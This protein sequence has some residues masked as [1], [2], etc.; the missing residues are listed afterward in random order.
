MLVFQTLK[1]SMRLSLLD[2]IYQDMVCDM[3]IRLYD[4]YFR[5]T[6]VNEKNNLTKGA[7]NATTKCMYCLFLKDA[8]ASVKMDNKSLF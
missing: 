2:L 4:S 1:L 5:K 8:M 3:V 6:L 7:L